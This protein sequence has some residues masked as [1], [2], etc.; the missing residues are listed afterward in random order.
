MQGGEKTKAKNRIMLLS[1]FIIGMSM[2]ATSIEPTSA[3]TVNVTSN[4]TNSQIQSVLNNASSGDTIN[5]L[6]AFYEN[7]Q[8]II[9]KTLNIVTSVGTVLSGSSSSNSAVFL[10][11]GSKSSGTTISGFI[12]NATGSGIIVNNTINV[13]IKN[14]SINAE[15][16]GITVTKS[17]NTTI[18]NDTVTNSTTGINVTNSK[19]TVITTSTVKNSKE[20]GIN[21]ENSVNTTINR[22][23][24]TGSG[25]RGINIYNSNKTTVNGSTIKNNGNNSTAGEYSNEGGVYVQK[26]NSVKITHN[27]I[28][29][30]SQ[31]VTTR[32]SSNVAINNNTIDDNY[33]EGILLSGSAINITIDTNEI[34]RNSNGIEIDYSS[35]GNVTILHN[36][37]AESVKDRISINI[38]DTGNG[39]NYGHNYRSST[40][41]VIKNNV[42]LRNQGRYIDGHDIDGN[43]PSLLDSNWYGLAWSGDWPSDAIGAEYFCCKIHTTPIRLVLIKTGV[44]TYTAYLVNA[45]GNYVTDIPDISVTFS[46]SGGYSKTVTMHNG[47][48]SVQIPATELGDGTI[49]VSS[50][51]VSASTSTFSTGDNDGTGYTKGSG[52]GDGSGD[53]SGDSSGNDDSGGSGDGSGDSTSG[54]NGGSGASGGSSSGASSGSSS[55]AGLVKESADLGSDGSSGQAGSNG[56]TTP[57]TKDTK[58]AQELFIDN[59]VK[60]PQF[61]SI[62]GIVLLIILIFAAYYRKDLMNMIQ[63]SRK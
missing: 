42:I 41:E 31:G 16:T 21:V 46:T 50:D 28:S 54:D 44:N 38:E 7:I 27:N 47:Q 45:S 3:A 34:K 33:G 23:N 49:T 40:G 63:K 19:N 39:I 17:S 62:V 14:D 9:N 36:T 20:D 1:V 55:T 57:Q 35:G 4:M 22:D 61:W 25:E 8:L 53:G 24:V 43:D 29:D 30:N 48:V 2:F 59:T 51:G 6:G 60:S 26:S 5:F 15:G 18:K 37:I 12:I 13:T 52:T 11:N 56:E 10:I 58:T 32:D